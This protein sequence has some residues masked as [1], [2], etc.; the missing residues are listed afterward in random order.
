MGVM[1]WISEDPWPLAG[2]LLVLAAMAVVLARLTQR[3][4]FLQ[5]AGLLAV[6]GLLVIGVERLWVT[7]RERVEATLYAVRDAAVRSD[8]PAL[9]AHLAPDFEMP[10]PLPGA[11]T[12]A[13]IKGRLAQYKFEW[14][15]LSNVQISEPGRQTRQS[16]AEFTARG[17]WEE[18]SPG[19]SPNFD[20]TPPR[21]VRFS[22]GFREVEPKV[23]KVTRIDLIDTGLPGVSPERALGSFGGR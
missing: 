8:F 5:A 12:K 21:G 10:G 15:A 9:E 13:Y 11:I 14:I 7:D 3:G 6:L 1:G 18:T 20:A 2:T 23:W 19:G 17:T 22:F 4:R 16:T